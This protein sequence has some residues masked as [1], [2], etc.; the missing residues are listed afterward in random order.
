MEVL[1][2]KFCDILN[3]N[4]GE[5][6]LKEW[7]D[8]REEELSNMDENDKKHLIN[9]DEY[10]EKILNNVTGES[11]NYVSKKLE[12]MYDDFID[13]CSYWNNK[14]YMSGFSDAIKLILSG[15]KL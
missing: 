11:Y 3:N 1:T 4:E 12:L 2:M 7:L 9:F 6:I 10:S 15:L 5:N 14:Y 8:F 13:Y